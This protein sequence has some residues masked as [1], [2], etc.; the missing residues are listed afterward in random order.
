MAIKN[1]SKSKI[2]YLVDLR[3]ETGKRIQR[4][5]NTLAEAKAFESLN[6][7]KKY[8]QKLINNK[9]LQPKYPIEQALDEFLMIKED[10]RPKSYQKY[11]FIVGQLK[12]FAQNLGIKYVGEF[13][14]DHATLLYK[15]LVKERKIDR[16]NH[17]ITIKPKPKTVN[18]FL[19]TTKSFF[20]IEVNKNHIDRSPMLHIK[21]LRVEKRNPEYYTYIE[22]KSFFNQKMPLAYR[23]AFMGFLLTG[24]RFQELA[25]LTWGDIDFKSRLLHV[26]PKEN[27]KTKTHN[28]QRAIPINDDLLKLLLRCWEINKDKNFVFC[29]Q[30]GTQLKARWTLRLCKAIAEA[31]GI[32]SRAFIHKFRHTFATYLIQKGVPIQSIK[33]LLGHWSVTMTEVYAHNKSDHMHSEVSV[34]NGLLP[35]KNFR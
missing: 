15:H 33:E 29:S 1:K 8:Q 9:L 12:L 14:P 20:K 35:E 26:R 32:K 28:A 25:N 16:G 27:F 23:Y 6:T 7:S 4:T 31:A 11:S 17:S 5:F 24:L 13:T 10:L 19:E 30:E 3:D 22:L 21:N 18:G 2:K 34:L